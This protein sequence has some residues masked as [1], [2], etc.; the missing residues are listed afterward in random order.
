MREPLE[1]LEAHRGRLFGI[2]YRMLG[3]VTEAEDV[4]QESF[5]R[6][7]E[8]SPADI[9]DARAFLV[10]VV[11]RICLDRLKAARMRREQYFG[12]WLPEPLITGTQKSPEDEAV[13]RESLSFALLVLLERLSPVERSV[14]VLREAFGYEY[15]EIG[16]IIGKSEGNCRVLLHRAKH[17]I[18]RSE[19]RQQVSAEER[20]RL[21][22]AFIAATRSGDVTRLVAALHDDVELVAD[23]GGK[24]PAAQRPVIGAEKVAAY[25]Y[26]LTSRFGESVDATI[27]EVNGEANVVLWHDGGV[28][29]IVAAE[30][31]ARLIR[32]LR[33]VVNPEKLTYAAWQLGVSVRPVLPPS[34]CTGH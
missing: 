18:Q 9:E 21:L 2:A 34:P 6:Y 8:Y 20:E 23:G 30:F 32:R 26:G 13:E 28:C 1:N 29:L 5:I 10:T 31:E 24:V 33:L 11:T 25:A 3:R 4:V 16:R 27:A 12:P 17:R 22:G 14:F 19:R 15:S 7:L